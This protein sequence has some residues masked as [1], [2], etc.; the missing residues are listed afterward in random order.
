MEYKIIGFN[1]SINWVNDMSKNFSIY[2]RDREGDR[3]FIID[4][5]QIDLYQ[6]VN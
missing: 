6:L 2:I 1:E 4:S 5:L 3:W